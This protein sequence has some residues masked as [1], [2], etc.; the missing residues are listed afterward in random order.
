M[1][2]VELSE[3]FFREAVRVALRRDSPGLLDSVSAAIM[4][5]GSEV[6]GF[7]DAISHDHNFSPRVLLLMDDAEY[8]RAGP[9]LAER[10]RGSLPAEFEGF[11]LLNQEYRKAVEV[12]PLH[13]HFHNYLGLAAL[14]EKDLDWLRC[15][16][17]R[18]LELTSGKVFHD[19]G[20][21][22]AALRT[23]LAHYPPAVRL[24]L[25][26]LCF[27]RMS[28]SAGIERAIRR[29]DAVATSYYT[30]WFSYFAIRACHLLEN[31]Y[32]PYHKWM[33]RSLER[34]GEFGRLMHDLVLALL[35]A[36]TGDATR[37]A[38]LAILHRLSARVLHE[39]GLPASEA[40]SPDSLILL[41]FDWESVLKPLKERL[42]VELKALS[43]L[44]SPPAYAGMLF[45]YSGFD[46]TYRQ[47]MEDNVR[48]TADNSQLTA[49]SPQPEQEQS[50]T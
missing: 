44:V 33:G 22:L 29:N 8:D 5:D 18:L 21:R 42:P 11:T 12:V 36:R 48:L 7:D 50:R 28:E 4:G 46:A 38:M 16:E 23:G 25:L 41:D 2:G 19:P 32:C 10:L 35:S 31:R 1:T 45:D 49:N 30:N 9:A 40:T 13:R 34:T 3:R 24:F 43:P 27:V 37:G 15:D 39:L 17:Q 14:P 6:L 20:G 26:R 47:V